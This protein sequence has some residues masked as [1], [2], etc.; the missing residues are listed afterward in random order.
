MGS[1]PGYNP[2]P[3]DRRIVTRR[4]NVKGKDLVA[5]WDWSPEELAELLAVRKDAE[6]VKDEISIPQFKEYALNL[7]DRIFEGD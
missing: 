5:L 6:I 7:I 1:D 2:A 3:P 4:P